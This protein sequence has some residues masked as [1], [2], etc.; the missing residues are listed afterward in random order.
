MDVES[1][2]LLHQR[3]L[4]GQDIAAVPQAPAFGLNR[5]FISE[6]FPAA[7]GALAGDVGAYCI[8]RFFISEYFPAV[9]K[10]WLILWAVQGVSIASSSANTFRRNRLETPDEEF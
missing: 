9:T 1:Q 2:S 5:F 4:S 10:T 8:N 3:I 6:Y 7:A